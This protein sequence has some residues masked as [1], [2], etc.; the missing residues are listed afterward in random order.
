MQLGDPILEAGLVAGL[1]G[2]TRPSAQYAASKSGVHISG[3]IG[4][5]EQSSRA[6]GSAF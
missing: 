2:A 1:Q 3:S 6:T 4:A 5:L